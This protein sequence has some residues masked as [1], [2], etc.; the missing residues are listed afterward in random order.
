MIRYRGVIVLSILILSP[1]LA[2]VGVL[3]AQ[4]HNMDIYFVDVE[5]GAATLVVTPAG[6]SLLIDTGN[7]VA[8]DRDA[9]RIYA[10]TQQAG[11]KKIDYL[12]T[13]HYHGDHVGGAPALAKMIPIEKFLDHGQS[14]ETQNARGAQPWEAYLKI[15]EGRRTIVKPGDKFPLKGV[16][17][18]VVSSNGEVLAKPIT[19]GGPNPACQGAQQKPPDQ[20]ENQRSVGILLTYGKFKF[21]DLGDLTWDKEMELAC[22][23]N[24][25]G[26]VNLYQVTHHGFFGGLS[27]APAHVWAIKPQVAVVNNGPRKG[28]SPDS[29][30]ETLAK[31]PGIEGIW[32]AHL[33]LAVDKDH[34]TS[35]QMIANLEDTGECKGNGIKAS[36]A[37]NGDF[38]VTNDRN[39][40]S[41]LYRSR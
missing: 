36:V 5:G 4:S 14:V 30:Y 32:Q 18:L 9:K 19:G 6:E 28:L 16:D 34:N 21:L 7:P 15:A 23:V 41:K 39:G 1:L 25:L 35:E 31:I 20:T 13:T 27:G 38:T 24:R 26:T 33:S 17:V 11:L 10:A 29:A 12:L 37:A 2:P 22:P 3:R 40:F 8:D